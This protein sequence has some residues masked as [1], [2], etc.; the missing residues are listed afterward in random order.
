[1]K[2]KSKKKSMKRKRMKRKK[3]KEMKPISRIDELPDP[4]NFKKLL[5]QKKLKWRN[6]E[7]KKE[8]VVINSWTFRNRIY[9]LIFFLRNLNKFIKLIL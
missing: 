9:K 2:K 8:N 6:K 3:E 1:M 5:V 4:L 7:I